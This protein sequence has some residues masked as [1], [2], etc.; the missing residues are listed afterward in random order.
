L[1]PTFDLGIK[2]F[3]VKKIINE[4]FKVEINK[5]EEAM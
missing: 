2:N 3:K 4:I 5:D 1:V